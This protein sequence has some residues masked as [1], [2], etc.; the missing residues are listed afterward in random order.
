M[1]AVDRIWVVGA[2]LKKSP[3]GSTETFL[4]ETGS[5]TSRLEIGGAEALSFQYESEL[6]TS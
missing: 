6:K 3:L 2:D 1:S 4:H 5:L